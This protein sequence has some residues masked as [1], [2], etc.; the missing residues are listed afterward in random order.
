MTLGRSRLAAAAIVVVVLVGVVAAGVLAARAVVASEASFDGPP[1]VVTTARV[2]VDPPP[3]ATLAASPAPTDTPAAD[4]TPKPT[5]PPIEI[6]TRAVAEKSQVAFREPTTVAKSAE[7]AQS[8][9]GTTFTW[10]DGGTTRRVVLQTDLVMLLAADVTPADVVVAGGGDVSIVQ[11][12]PRH[13]TDAAPAFRSQSGESLMTLP[14]GVLLLLSPA[15][16]ESQVQSF[17]AGNGIALTRVSNLGPLPSGFEIETDPGFPSLHL[18]NALAGQEGVV[19][20]SP[21]WWREV[22]AK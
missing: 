8:D 15:W 20:A 4:P 14:G 1:R 2:A 6:G 13:G 9:Q 5:E 22:E 10:Q 11:K 7:A 19:L 21:N 17:F 16:D 12:E 18:A 3:A